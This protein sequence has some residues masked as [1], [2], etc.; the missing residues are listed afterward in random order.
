MFINIWDNNLSTGNSEQGPPLVGMCIH[1]VRKHSS[2][3]LFRIF[4]FA[5]KPI[6]RMGVSFEFLFLKY[7]TTFNQ[8][9]EVVPASALFVLFRD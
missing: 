9:L 3:L 5:I 1:F 8:R 2:V 7:T 4:L 6:G